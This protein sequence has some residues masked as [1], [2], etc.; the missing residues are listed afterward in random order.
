MTS[1]RLDRIGRGGVKARSPVSGSIPTAAFK[2]SPTTQPQIDTT[3]GWTCNLGEKRSLN[4]L[5]HG[6][7]RRSRSETYS[8]DNLVLHL[9]FVILQR[10]DGHPRLAGV[11][12]M[13]RF[14]VVAQGLLGEPFRVTRFLGA[15]GPRVAIAVQT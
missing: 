15:F 14:A 11:G 3:R 4:S 2:Y 9:L 1:R 6:R 8:L 13:H 12:A 7:G 5:A 10:G